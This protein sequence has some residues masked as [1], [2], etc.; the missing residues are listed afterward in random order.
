MTLF[1]VVGGGWAGLAAASTLASAGHGVHLFEMAPQLGGRARNAQFKPSNPLKGDETLQV[2]NGQHLLMGAY[3]QT[4]ALCSSLAG[5]SQFEQL[6]ERMPVTLHSAGGIDLRAPRF[7]PAPLHLAVALIGASGLSLLER[8]R[9]IQLLQQLKK[10]RWLAQEQDISVAQLLA[11]CKQPASLVAQIWRPLCLSALNTPLELSSAKVFAAVMRD[12]LAAERNASDFLVARVPLGDTLPKLVQTQL[13]QAPHAIYLKTQVLAVH[14]PHHLTGPVL[15][16]THADKTSTEYAGVA[17]ATPWFTTQALLARPVRSELEQLPI[18]TIYAYWRHSSFGARMRPLMLRDD[19]Q[20]QHYG[21]WL[22]DLGDTPG[23][24]RLASVVISGPG[25][26]LDLDRE[27]LAAAIGKQIHEQTGW[28]VPDDYL[29]ITEK[30]ATFAC[31]VN[32]ARP[33]PIEDVPPQVALCGDYFK[34]EYPATLETA[35]RSGIA[36]AHRLL[37]LASV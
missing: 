7:L 1:A 18:V 30:R 32:V 10:R 2:D 6:F 5:T 4:N 19:P 28:I 17:L 11:Q 31:T 14:R 15:I 24:G 36:A 34:S 3:S 33:D 12:T 16:Q 35:V 25:A 37:K 20:K 29:V 27:Q 13:S 22:F 26:H 23:S 8:L 21:H 9:L